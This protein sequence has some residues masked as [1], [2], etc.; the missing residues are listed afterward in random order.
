MAI[1]DIVRIPV[2]KHVGVT[3]LSDELASN[4]IT[5]AEHVIK[6][7]AIPDIR[8]GLK[9]VHRRILW[10]M[11][12]M[13]CKHNSTFKKSARIV[14]DTIGKFHPHGDQSVYDSMVRM[15]QSFSMS[16]PLVNGKGN[17]G[18]IDGHPAAAYRYTEA[19]LSAFGEHALFADI[20]DDTVSYADNYTGEFIEPT[21]LP[22]RL[23][24]ILLTAPAGIAVG[25]ATNFLPHNLSEVCDAIFMMLDDSKVSFEEIFKAIPAPDYPLG[26]LIRGNNGIS[27]V[28][29]TGKGGIKF[30]ASADFETSGKAKA[31]IIRNVPYTSNKATLI[32]EIAKLVRDGELVGISEVRDESTKDG[33]RICIELSSGTNHQLVLN[34]LYS[35]TGL[36]TSNSMNMVAIVGNRPRVTNIID[37]LKCFLDF[38][39]EVITRRTRCRKKKAESRFETIEGVIKATQKSSLTLKIIK[40]SENPIAVIQERLGLTELQADHI[41][42]MPLR[43]FSRQDIAK[44]EEERSKLKIYISELRTILESKTKVNEII[45]SETQEIR[46]KFGKPRR[47]MIVSDFTEIS[48]RDMIKDQE[49][50]LTFMSDGTVKSTPVDDYR[51]YKRRG[52]GVE[53]VKVPDGVYPE[54]AKQVNT[55]SDVMLITDQGNRYKMRAFDVPASSRGKRPRPVS[56]YVKLFKKDEKV[57]SVTESVLSDV[58]CLII[59]GENGLLK[60]Q[61]G[62]TVMKIRDKT[63][64]IYDTDRGGRVISAV[65]AKNNDEVI[66]VTANGLVLRTSLEDIREVSSRLSAGVK[67]LKLQ[68]GD[69]LLGVTV[70]NPTGHLL[71]VSSFG[72]A[73]RTPMSDFLLKRRGGKGS[74]GFRTFKEGDNLVFAQ[75]VF[76]SDEESG[77]FLL[78][79]ENKALRLNFSNV[80]EFGKVSQGNRMKRMSEGEYVTAVSVE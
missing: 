38:R 15:A 65:V 62:Q 77:L 7:R 63:T 51:M 40:E 29:S 67:I 52:L 61:S 2:T 57:V 53:G 47:T 39:R 50:V 44:L 8:D 79:N 66:V 49:V 59:L 80:P 73:K 37:V 74:R 56:N 21:V 1:D 23:P 13:G 9:P 70:A 68:T 4:F 41:F 48:V 75:A 78:T 5:Y 6:E 36:E 32:Q 17:F 55:R 22:S 43:R 64:K 31:I 12:N 60:K 54:F 16:V 27:E 72:Y 25:M 69:S 34:R 30:R 11:W 10:T 28:Y 58:E 35:M 46:D 20:A 71:T 24:L 19:R 18:S 76:A 14:G 26:G 45:R 33:I 3:E 42:N